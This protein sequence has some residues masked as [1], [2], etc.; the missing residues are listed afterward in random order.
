MRPSLVDGRQH[1]GARRCALNGQNEAFL[2]IR[3]RKQTGSVTLTCGFLGRISDKFPLHAENLRE[4]PRFGLLL[5][6]RFPVGGGDGG[7]ALPKMADVG[8]QEPS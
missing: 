5:A 2:V 4:V 8:V 6:R 7:P 3:Y 1:R